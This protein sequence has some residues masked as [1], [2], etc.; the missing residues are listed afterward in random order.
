MLR[1]LAQAETEALI[2]AVGADR[3]YD[4]LG[5]RLDDVETVYRVRVIASKLGG[6]EINVG[7][8]TI[9]RDTEFSA[10]MVLGV[11]ADP[12]DLDRFVE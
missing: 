1:S 2:A 3:G 6:A 11:V 12:A 5:H 4:L 10:G 7:P 9:A 8:G